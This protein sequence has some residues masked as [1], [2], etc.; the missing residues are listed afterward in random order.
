MLFIR[1]ENGVVAYLTTKTSTFKIILGFVISLVFI[2]IGLVIQS[3]TAGISDPPSYSQY[4]IGARSLTD[5]FTLAGAF[6]GSVS[7]YVLMKAKV[8]FFVDGTWTQKIIRYMI[9]IV[10]V[11][12]T[13]Y[14]LD[15]LF[16]L[17]AVDDSVIG[18]VLRYIR[19]GST[20]FWVMVG[21]PWVF[22]K[23]NLYTRL[24]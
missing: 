4:S 8:N 16:G 12:I 18:Y 20:T 11:L 17:I 15:I 22:G 23:F 19:Y 7:G 6:M 10:G 3:I 14:G 1:F 2:L 5:Y 13:M 24:D 21:A 9:G